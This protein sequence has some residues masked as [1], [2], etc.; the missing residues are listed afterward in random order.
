MA[1]SQRKIDFRWIFTTGLAII[2]IAISVWSV[3]TVNDYNE[4]NTHISISQ[5][6]INTCLS[7]AQQH[8]EQATSIHNDMRAGSQTEINQITL[9]EKREVVLNFQKAAVEINSCLLKNSNK[10]ICS[11]LILSSDSSEC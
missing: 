5:T 2:A 3:I 9:N 6:R 11:E 7:L 4:E 1:S 10:E 8:L